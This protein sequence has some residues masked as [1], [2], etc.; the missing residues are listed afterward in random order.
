MSG[1]DGQDGGDGT[2][3]LNATDTKDFEVTIE[4]LSEDVN[5][6]TKEYRIEHSGP[7]GKDEQTV[8]IDIAR[9]MFYV[10][11]KGGNGGRG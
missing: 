7:Y 4:L 11:A 8:N 3:G 9:T 5:R 10:R 6:G 2:D 1:E